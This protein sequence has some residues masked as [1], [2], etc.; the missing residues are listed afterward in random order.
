M[1][2]LGGKG[3]LGIWAYQPGQDIFPHRGWLEIREDGPTIMKTALHY[4]AALVAALLSASVAGTQTPS[5][6]WMTSI[7]ASHGDGKTAD[8]TSTTTAVDPNTQQSSLTGQNKYYKDFSTVCIVRT[9]PGGVE[10]SSSLE[11]QE[12]K[13]I[14]VP[15]PV[16]GN[17]IQGMPT[18]SCTWNFPIAPGQSYRMTSE[19]HQWLDPYTSYPRGA[20]GAGFGRGGQGVMGRFDR[21]PGVCRG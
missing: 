13:N 14:S 1:D 2:E 16:L 3:G 6:V 15:N 4:A 17:N 7:L 5:T 10:V 12:C 21:P 18:S 20:C 11:A 8:T 9:D 19:H